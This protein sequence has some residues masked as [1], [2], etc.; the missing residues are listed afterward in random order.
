MSYTR[1]LTYNVVGG[2]LWVAVCVGAGYFFGNLP[3]VKK[4]FSLVILAIILDLD[5][6]DGDRVPAPP[7]RSE[8]PGRG[9]SRSRWGS[10]EDRPPVPEPVVS[11]RL[12]QHRDQLRGLEALPAPRADE[13]QR[14]ADLVGRDAGSRAGGARRR[15][16]PSGRRP[17]LPDRRRAARCSTSPR[18]CAP[19]GCG[20]RAPAVRTKRRRASFSNG[21]LEERGGPGQAEG[22][23]EPHDAHR[24]RR[25]REGPGGSSSR[26]RA[27]AITRNTTARTTW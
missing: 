4:N 13:E 24:G 6:A 20:G 22:E 25:G 26:T 17:P 16:G 10:V 27:R 1:F 7:R 2:V 11:R 14:P 18:T 21:R 23:G 9:L 5:D 8:A 12:P 3:F 19:G 15:A